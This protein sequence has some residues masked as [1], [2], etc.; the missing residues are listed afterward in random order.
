MRIGLIGCGAAANL[1]MLAYKH[2]EDAKVEA[3][4]DLD[5]KKAKA[6][7]SKYGIPRTFAKYSDLLE[8]EG[9][10]LIDICTPPSTHAIISCEAA[11]FGYHILLE[12]PMARTTAECDRIIAECNRRNVNLCV[13][14]TELFNVS[15]QDAKSATDYQVVRCVR[16]ARP[17]SSWVMNPEEGGMLW[18]LGV[19]QAYLQRYFLG[20]I[21]EVCATGSRAG[22]MSCCDI[23]SVL[24]SSNGNYGIMELRWPRGRSE[25]FLELFG[26]NGTRKI[27]LS[28]FPKQEEFD[29]YSHN[30]L[31]STKEYIKR[32]RSGLRFLFSPKVRQNIITNSLHLE[33]IRRYLENIRHGR[34]PPVNP[35]EGREAVKL[36]EGIDFSLRARKSVE[37]R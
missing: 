20:N 10:D 2:L 19:H 29:I 34:P 36:L 24:K 14:H 12:K 30:L 7:S 8:V 15:V 37:L 18:D 22:D 35:S 23:T 1:H 21:V 28:W 9:L 26:M 4:S 32:V 5:I 27:D 3:I 17:H 13:C 31:L 6:F 16:S 25:H 11:R 33:L